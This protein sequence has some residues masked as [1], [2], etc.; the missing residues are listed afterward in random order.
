MASSREIR[1]ELD[2]GDACAGLCWAAANGAEKSNAKT[3]SFT[4][5][6]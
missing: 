4:C 6:K 5:L 2:G 3:K 1:A